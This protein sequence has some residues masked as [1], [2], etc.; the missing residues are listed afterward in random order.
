VIFAPLVH[1]FL[2]RLHADVD[3]DRGT[4]RSGAE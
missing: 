4:R 1:R 3:P 2:H